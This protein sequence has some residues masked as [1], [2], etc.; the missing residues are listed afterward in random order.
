MTPTVCDQIL[1]NR[2]KWYKV[3]EGGG[4]V[5]YDVYHGKEHVSS[6]LFGRERDGKRYYRGIM[7]TKGRSF[8]S[9][10]LRNIEMML[11]AP[12]LNPNC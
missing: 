2:L 4:W 1:L 6:L 12:F 11:A 3:Y 9:R 5:L 7:Y 8:Y 10:N